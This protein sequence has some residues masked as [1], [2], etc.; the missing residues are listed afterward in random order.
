MFPLHL[1]TL[2]EC[3]PDVVHSGDALARIVCR[4]SSHTH[5]Q[6]QHHTEH[7]H[8]QSEE[9]HDESRHHAEGHGHHAQQ[10]PQDHVASTEAVDQ[11]VREEGQ[12]DVDVSGALDHL[13]VPFVTF[14]LPFGVGVGAK[15]VW[16]VCGGY[17]GGADLPKS[18]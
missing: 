12:L 10:T 7:D 5:E 2:V 15:G 9:A 11:N 4:Q 17:C 3:T 6:T 13:Q 1:V 18:R 14:F 16:H 8:V